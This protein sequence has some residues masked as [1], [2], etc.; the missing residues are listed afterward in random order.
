MTSKSKKASIN[1]NST[2]A[3][4]PKKRAPRKKKEVTKEDRMKLLLEAT[5]QVQKFMQEL[6]E[7]E[8]QLQCASLKR[9]PES[10]KQS[11]I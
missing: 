2:P 10:K 9:V 7:D 6:K 5:A 1:D 8:Q 3:A 4:E 11:V